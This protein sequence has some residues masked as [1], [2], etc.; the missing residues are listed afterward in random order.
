MIEVQN[1]QSLDNED[2]SCVLAEVTFS[3]DGYEFTASVYEDAYRKTRYG[4]PE[5]DIPVVVRIKDGDFEDLVGKAPT[6]NEDYLG[7]SCAEYDLQLEDFEREIS[8]ALVS[9]LTSRYGISTGM[10]FTI[11]VAN[12]DDLPAVS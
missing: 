5:H 11:F 7:E 12:L 2:Q 9:K 4:M 6:R 3:S 10:R 8:D 1:I